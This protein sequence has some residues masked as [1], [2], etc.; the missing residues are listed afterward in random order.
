MS[1]S[2]AEKFSPEETDIIRAAFRKRDGNL[3]C[4]RC[5]GPL[6]S[7]VYGAGGTIAPVHEISCE[8]CK[9]HALAALGR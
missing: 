3:R 4:P 1:E 8:S 7:M 9:L 6:V 5:E 2:Q